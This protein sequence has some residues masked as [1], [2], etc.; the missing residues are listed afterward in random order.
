V[1]ASFFDGLFIEPKHPIAR[2]VD[3]RLPR[4]PEQFHGFRIAQIS[5]IHFG[6]YMGRRG[7][8]R[9]L[10]V[11]RPFN[12]DL[13]VLTGDFVSHPLG[14][15]HGRAGALNA[16]PCA[17]VLT[18]W[19]GC[20][21]AAV[22]GNH[23][24]WNDPQIVAGALRER[25]IPLLNNA[26]YPLEREGKRL[27]I[28]GVD[29]PISRAADLPQALRN[30]PGSEMTV[31]LAH[32][33]DYADYVSRFPIDLQLSGHSHG[34]QVRLPGMGAIV[35]PRM[36]TKYPMGLYQI[37]K[38]QLYTNVGVGVVTPPVRFN[39]P[40]EVTCVTLLGASLEAG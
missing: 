12:P 25:R 38:M 23:D 33:P 40:P 9:V 6:P 27:W 11:A 16:E 3:I 5:D 4:L 31:L 10:S 36:A 37:G 17:D 24:H 28:V 32:E 8:E 19:K 18:Q 35:L 39:C 21:M 14:R 1:G 20:P 13:L 26:A 22:L 15:T 29:D 34:G 30:V 7:L 2:H